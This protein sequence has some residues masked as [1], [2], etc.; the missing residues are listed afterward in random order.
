MLTCYPYNMSAYSKVLYK[1]KYVSAIDKEILE[2]LAIILDYG[3]DLTLTQ[4]GY[5]GGGVAASAG[6]HDGGAAFDLSYY[7]AVQKVWWLRLLGVAASR[8]FKPPFDSEHIHGVVIGNTS[9]SSGAKHQV[10]QYLNGTNGLANYGKDQDRR[11]I[12]PNIQFVFNSR[13]GDWYTKKTTYGYS[14]PNRKATKVAKRNKNAF[15]IVNIA[16]VKVWEKSALKPK[17]QW[18]EW[19]VTKNGTFYK[20]SDLKTTAP[21]KI[22]KKKEAWTVNRDTLNGYDKPN[23][24]AKVKR[25]RGFVLYTNAST[26]VKGETWVKHPAGKWYRKVGLTRK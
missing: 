2:A 12:N 20:K 6:T 13:V 4:G 8:R 14:Q 10:A 23:G 16:T 7:Q 1:G 21:L 5:N 22:V 15:H 24:K 17:G 3:N 11:P 9:A 19:I 25:K 18:V 26:T